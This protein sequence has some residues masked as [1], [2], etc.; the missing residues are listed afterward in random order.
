M[1]VQNY[2][3]MMEIGD[4]LEN[5]AEYWHIVGAL[6]YNIVNQLFHFMRNPI[7]C[8]WCAAKRVL[9]YLKRFC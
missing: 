8:H 2:H 5:V 4:H 7:T 3:N 9:H 1:L 6:Q